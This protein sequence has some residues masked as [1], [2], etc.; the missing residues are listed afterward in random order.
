M[1]KTVKG[2]IEQLYKDTGIRI[3]KGNT[4]APVPDMPYATYN[5][6]S[7]Y[8]KD[9]GQESTTY[10]DTGDEL[11]MKREEQYKTVISFNVYGDS[12]ETAINLSNGLRQWF[13]FYGQEFIKAQ[14]V[15]VVMVGDI[16]NRTTFL[17]DSYEYKH[18][19]DVQL[20]LTDKQ[21]KAIDYF[22]RV[23]E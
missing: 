2:I 6:I 12:D 10:E 15:A 9:V 13:L 21:E 7:P 1:I 23:G 19:F 14:N 20:R 8:L 16:Q 3:I 4:T 17:V 18:G 22:D 5:L 11:L